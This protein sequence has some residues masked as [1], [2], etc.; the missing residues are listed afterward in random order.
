MSHS[1]VCELQRLAGND[2]CQI[3]FCAAC[4]VVHLDVGPLSL[5]LPPA[6]YQQVCAAMVT[7]S[8]ILQAAGSARETP[9]RRH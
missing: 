2:R 9:A 3:W 1:K 5:K 4:N 7:A 8:A 6:V